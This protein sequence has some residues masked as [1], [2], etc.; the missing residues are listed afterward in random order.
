MFAGVTSKEDLAEEDL[1]LVI[2]AK[3]FHN[4]QHTKMNVEN[5]CFS[6]LKTSVWRFKFTHNHIYFLRVFHDYR[7]RLDDST[8]ARLR[9]LVTMYIKIIIREIFLL[10]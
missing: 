9:F 6:R 7:D 8:N 4:C 3:V 10:L 2:I 5:L 1:G